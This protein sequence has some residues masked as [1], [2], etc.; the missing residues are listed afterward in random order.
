MI[1]SAHFLLFLLLGFTL[2][3]QKLDKAKDLLSKKKLTEAKTEIDNFLA[4]EKNKGNNDALYV[5]GKVYQEIARDESLKASVENPRQIAFDCFKQYMLAESGKDSTKRNLAIMMDNYGPVYDLYREYSSAG[6]TTYQANDFKG[7]A[8][9]FG[10][11]LEVF[12]FLMQYKL[13]NPMFDTTTTLYAGISAEKAEDKELAAKYYGL[14]A[15]KKIASE[16]FVDIYKWL[17]D[18]YARKADKKETDRFLG[19]GKAAYP[20]DSYWAEFSYDDYQISMLQDEIDAIRDKGDMQ[21]VF[22]KYEEILASNGYYLFIFNYAVELI[23]YASPVEGQQKPA[24]AT[25]LLTKATGL[26]N[27][28]KELKPEYPNTYS[29]LGSLVYNEINDLRD[30]NKALKLNTAKVLKPE[31]KKANEEISKKKEAIQAQIKA[32]HDDALVHFLKVDDLLGTKIRLKQ[33]EKEVLK[34]ALDNL[35]NIYDYKRDT[36]KYDYYT[37]KFNELQIPVKMGMAKEE[38]LRK[39]GKPDRIENTTTD[40]G[41]TEIYHYKRGH[42][43]F[44]EAGKVNYIHD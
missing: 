2:Q 16:G 11:S 24:N 18:F 21:A 6:A 34:N 7:A 32:K 1:R 30:Q 10:K 23:Q 39:F 5:K 12:D 25:E 44:D 8:E 27:R 19:Y 38:I 40:T 43:G 26:L 35:I 42:V 4:I 9:N 33:D 14:I 36:E 3:A 15:E 28:C 41:K 20:A 22:A 13:V 17:I 29:L 31:E 37:D